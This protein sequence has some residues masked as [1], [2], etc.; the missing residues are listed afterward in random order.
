[1]RVL[2]RSSAQK[3]RVPTIPVLRRKSPRPLRRDH[4]K[5]ERTLPLFERVWM[6]MRVLTGVVLALALSSTA[7][8]SRDGRV[9]RPT[10]FVSPFRRGGN[11]CSQLA[12]VLPSIPR[13]SWSSGLQVFIRALL[14]VRL[15][16]TRFLRPELSSSSSAGRPRPPAA[17]ISSRAARRSRRC[18]QCAARA[19]SASTDA[20]R[21][22]KSRSAARRT[23]RRPGQH[24]SRRAG[25][26]CWAVV[27]PR[28][29]TRLTKALDQPNEL[30]GTVTLTAREL[31]QLARLGNHRPRLGCGNGHAATTAEVQ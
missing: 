19:S 31:D 8:A 6:L 14:S 13:R 17:A 15:R 1:V 16:L 20:A 18:G 22:R 21:S 26:R 24:T 12:T 27:Q 4:A 30:V 3:V 2:G 23:R 25:T 7:A 5:A 9:L 11:E 10:V 28:A 29:L